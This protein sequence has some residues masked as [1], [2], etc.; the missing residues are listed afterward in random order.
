MC[1]GQ[2]QLP[3]TKLGKLINLIKGKYEIPFPLPYVRSDDKTMIN[4]AMMRELYEISMGKRTIKI[5]LW[6]ACIIICSL[7]SN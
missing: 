3:K 5:M 4:A 2:R 6:I 7:V 1:D